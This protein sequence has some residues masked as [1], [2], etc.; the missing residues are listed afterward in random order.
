MVTIYKTDVV[1]NTDE[2][3]VV[4]GELRGLSD[5]PKPT[6]NFE[7]K[8]IGNG[9]VFVEIDTQKLFFFD[10]DSQEWKGE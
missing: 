4:Y 6:S 9:C 10:A 1:K 8:I 5:D 3:Q 7:G 2:G